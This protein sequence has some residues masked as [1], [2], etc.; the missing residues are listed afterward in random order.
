M[1]SPAWRKTEASG[2]QPQLSSHLTAFTNYVPAMSASHLGTGSSQ[3]PVK[4]P[5]LM[6]SE[7]GSNLPT[8][9]CQLQICEQNNDRCCFKLLSFELVCYI[10]NNQTN[11]LAQK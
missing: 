10:N 8:E 4:P 7:A 11:A 6:L 3:A 5:Q 9:A 2:P 1:E